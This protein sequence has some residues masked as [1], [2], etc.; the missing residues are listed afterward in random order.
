M[1]ATTYPNGPFFYA[2]FSI[3]IGEAS[4]QVASS[5]QLVAIFWSFKLFLGALTDCFPLFGF[6]RKS[7]M[8]LG[9]FLTIGCLLGAVFLGQPYL[10]APS[11]KWLLC[12][13][14]MNLGFIVATTAGDSFMTE[15]AKRE[16]ATERGNIQ[17]IYY[18]VRH[19]RR[20]CSV[21]RSNCFA[22]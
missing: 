9:W 20:N 17:A 18:M 13:C 12:F 8:L 15:L 4:Y 5:A 11:W 2:V 7:Y 14:G 19:C 10:H 1:Q 21:A 16:H 6:R 3:L 22:C